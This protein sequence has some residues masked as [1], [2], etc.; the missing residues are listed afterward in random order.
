MVV[1]L[2]SREEKNEHVIIRC[3]VLR[4]PCIYVCSHAGSVS[5]CRCKDSPYVIIAA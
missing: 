1:S 4:M 5:L 2:T 3:R